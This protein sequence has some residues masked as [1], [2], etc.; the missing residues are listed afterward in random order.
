MGC[1]CDE[2][3]EYGLKREK[4]DVTAGN[5]MPIYVTTVRSLMS[6]YWDVVMNHC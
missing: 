1:H 3:G 6:C 4:A 2:R 5:M